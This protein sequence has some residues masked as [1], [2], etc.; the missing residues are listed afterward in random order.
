MR[1]R[2]N[3][4]RPG[5]AEY[6]TTDRDP[7]SHVGYITLDRGACGNAFDSNMVRQFCEALTAHEEDDAIKAIVLRANGPH[8]S[9][10]V[11]IAEIAEIFRP[12]PAER[13]EKRKLLNQRIRL[14]H[15]RDLWWGPEG[16]C[17]RL[18]HCPK[19][20]VVAA[21][22]DCF[23]TGLYFALY[24][25]LTIAD[26]S[27]RFG[28]PKWAQIGVDGDISMLIAAVGLRRA[29]ELI[30][31][32]RIWSAEQALAYGLIDAVVPGDRLNA[33]A[34]QLARDCATIMRDAI[35]AEKAI[36]VASLARMQIAMGM[37]AGAVLSGWATN[38]HFREGEFNMLKA[39]RDFGQ[40][41]AIDRA[42]AYFDF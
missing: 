38:V 39:V 24:A 10:G 16:L 8:F 15:G 31:C 25:D 13:N 12:A 30:Y 9:T 18:L 22:G 37:A 11:H 29:K 6:I 27:A 36:V 3:L 14:T 35:A 34:L 33:E 5:M 20:T 28:N 41:E 17:Q 40:D 7:G 21:H 4:G 26:P 32:N 2:S 1:R 19:I 42:R 23:E